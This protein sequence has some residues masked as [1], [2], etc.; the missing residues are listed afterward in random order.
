MHTQ[1]SSLPLL[2]S[3]VRPVL[4]FLALGL[5]GL[6]ARA[7]DSLA[8][9]SEASDHFAAGSSLAFEAS[10]Q[11]LSQG[12]RPLAGLTA[13]PVWMAGGLSTALGESARAAGTDLRAS[14]DALWDFAEGDDAADRP[15]L[16]ARA[17][18]PRPTPERPARSATGTTSNPDPRPGALL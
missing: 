1:T 14:G 17:G 6:T 3:R 16:D 8:T 9:A 15:A 10:G 12:I 11:A 4:T 18:Q 5:G 13:I 2:R 7:G